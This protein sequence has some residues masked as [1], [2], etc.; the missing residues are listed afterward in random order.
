MPPETAELF[1]ATLR[2]F[3][4]SALL[5]GLTNAPDGT[6]R[7]AFSY[8]S[9][10]GA[11]VQGAELRLRA[12]L[13]GRCRADLAY[14]VRDFEPRG[15]AGTLVSNAPDHAVAAQLR[16]Q[17][18]RLE[19]A[20]AYRWRSEFEW[21]SGIFRGPVPEI[22]LL[23]LQARLALGPHAGLEVEMRNALDRSHY[24]AFGGDLL[25]RQAAARLA[26][27]W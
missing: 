12:P 2:L 18:R 23:D 4:P 21:A 13:G 5:A 17:G 3:L 16:C 10:S 15:D 1:L 25:G 27:A 14:R 8:R 22:Q 26:F 7:V 24:Q 11:R 9:G 6:P 19:A 20:A